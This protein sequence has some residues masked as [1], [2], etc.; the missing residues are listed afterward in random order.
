M[1][2]EVSAVNSCRHD[3]T[4]VSKNYCK[5][6]ILSKERWEAVAFKFPHLTA[7]MKRYNIRSQVS[8]PVFSFFM[9]HF[10]NLHIIKGITWENA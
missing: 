9:H 8:N 7:N 10:E 2:G 1:F 5:L 3:C 6:A 4:S